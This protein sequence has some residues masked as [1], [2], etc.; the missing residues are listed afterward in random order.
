MRQNNSLIAVARSSYGLCL[1]YHQRKFHP[2]AASR[3]RVVA[4][5]AAVAGTSGRRCPAVSVMDS[6]C[7]AVM[8]RL[9]RRKVSASCGC[10]GCFP[11]SFPVVCRAVPGSCPGISPVLC[12]AVPGKDIRPRAVSYLPAVCLAG[13]LFVC[14]PSCGEEV[15]CPSVR[16]LPAPFRRHPCRPELSR[17]TGRYAL[18]PPVS[19]AS[20]QND[21]HLFGG[22]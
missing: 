5:G 2:C 19:A 22:A 18:W 12:R 16:S 14:C 10:A 6:I 13:R 7:V 4:V 9:H 20:R 15:S 11:Q 8:Y 17:G 21:G 1:L 3:I